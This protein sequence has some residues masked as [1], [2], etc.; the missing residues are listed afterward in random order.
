LSSD[1]FN[2][3]KLHDCLSLAMAIVNLSVV[4]YIF[5]ANRQKSNRERKEDVTDE[6]EQRLREWDGFWIQRIAL[7]PNLALL[8]EFFASCEDLAR[9]QSVLLSAPSQERSDLVKQR[10]ES[11]NQRL[12]AL[13]SRLEDALLISDRSF[14]KLREVTDDV[15]DLISSHLESALQHDEQLD[16][17]TQEKSTIE[18]IQA[19]RTK[20]F[21]TLYNQVR[22]LALRTSLNP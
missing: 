13:R 6:K 20:Y 2:D 9:G 16:L 19:L 10:V 4:Y 5:H 22:P 11:F 1:D 3:L 12:Y 18:Q 15:Q 17:R 14:L 8:N 7:E 21:E